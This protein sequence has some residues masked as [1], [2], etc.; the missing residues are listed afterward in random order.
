MAVPVIKVGYLPA[1]AQVH[2]SARGYRL[3]LEGS[4]TAART[5]S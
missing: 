5:Q 4:P 2:A 3:V 1:K